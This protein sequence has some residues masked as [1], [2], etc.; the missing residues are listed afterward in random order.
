MARR[1]T[2]EQLA[3]M[4]ARGFEDLRREMLEGFASIHAVL[5][6][7]TGTLATHSAILKEHTAILVRHSAILEDHSHRLDRIE[8][9]L[10]STI[11]RVD[12]HDVRIQAFER[13]RH[14]RS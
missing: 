12:D 13:R 1:I 8:R 11:R 3:G 14:P 4:V 7:H 6:D 9:K 2:I 5:D 10:D